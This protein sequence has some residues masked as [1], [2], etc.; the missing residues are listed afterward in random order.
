MKNN[1]LDKPFP[2]YEYDDKGRKMFKIIKW[3]SGILPRQIKKCFNGRIRI[4]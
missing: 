4:I 3:G 2:D 1:I